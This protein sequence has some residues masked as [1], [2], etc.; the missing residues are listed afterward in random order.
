MSSQE[1]E[2]SIR[3]KFFYLRFLLNERQR[4]CWAAS[5]SKAVGRGGISIVSRA[6]GLTRRTIYHG[7][8]D[9]EEGDIHEPESI[10]RTGAGRKKSTDEEPDL[11]NA[12]EDLICPSTRGDPEA[13]LKWTNK[14]TRN[15]AEE[16]TAHGYSVKYRTVNSLLHEL[17]YSLQSTRKTR[18]GVQHPDRD[19]QFQYINKRVK[20]CQKLR[21][22]VISV[23]TKKKELIGDFANKGQEWQPAGSPERVR[24]HDFKDKE[25]GKAIPYGV[26]DVTQNNG[27]VSVGI[28]HDTASFAIATIRRWWIRMGIKTYPKAKELLITSDSGG[29]NSSRNRLWKVSL[30]ELADE[31]GLKLSVCHFP[32]GTSKW[33]KIEH[34]MFCHISQNWRGR[35]LETLEVIVNLIGNT[36]TKKGLKI[37]ADTDLKDY[38]LGIKISDEQLATVHLARAK[39]HGDWNYTISPR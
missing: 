17:G 3:T 6:T 1:L 10:R 21:Q 27:W 13:P 8:D 19:A 37:I 9:I 7:L 35:P 5:E 30:Q 14:S 32:P 33:N 24:V 34:R 16:L 11:L 26:Y 20:A 39:F 15:L 2:N 18:E 12:L 28:T 36:K 38:E 25:L 31:L 23:D 4:R 29:S 22:P